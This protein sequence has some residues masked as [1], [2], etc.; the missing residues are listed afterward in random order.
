M[1][2]NSK[3]TDEEEGREKRRNRDAKEAEGKRK[4]KV[5]PQHPGPF[6]PLIVIT[7]AYKS[8]ASDQNLSLLSHFETI[9]TS[10]RFF[11]FKVGIT[12]GFVN[13]YS[14]ILQINFE[15]TI[16]RGRNRT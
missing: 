12:Y 10:A 9:D 16:K 6:F 7:T 2:R 14:V 5:L 3:E 13:H 11:E 1:E 15:V 4:G 8:I